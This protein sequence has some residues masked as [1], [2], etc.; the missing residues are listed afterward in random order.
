M[1]A[2]EL[3]QMGYPEGPLI[4]KARA[5]AGNARAA[6]RPPDQ[7]KGLMRAVLRRPHD[8]RADP[9]FGGLAQALI[10]VGAV[11]APAE[12]PAACFD[13][14]HPLEYAVWG[15]DIDP[16]AHEQMRNACRL[17]ISLAA[18]LMPDAHVGYGLPIGGVLAT[19]NAV[20][21]YAVGVDIA[22]RMMLTVFPLP[23]ES[24]QADASRFKKVLEANTRFGIGSEWKVPR[25]HPVMDED[26]RVSPVTAE[27]KNLAHRQLGTS[28][29]GNHFV[30]FGELVVS[31]PVKGLLPGRYLAV[32]SHSGS[33]GTGAKV[34]DYYSK[35]AMSRHQDMP[36]ELRHLAWL[37]LNSAGAEYWAA[38]E[39]MGKYASANHH[40]IHRQI[41]AAVGADPLLQIENHHN[42]AWREWHNGR[43]VIVHRKGATP[44]GRGMLGII[45][46]SM[47]TPG[48]VV[49]GLGSELSL[50]S[51]A[52][53]AGRRMSRKQAI[54]QFTW[55][56]AKP[57]L[58][59]RG[60]TLISAGIDEVPWVYKDIDEVMAAQCD[61]VRPLAKFMPRLVKM[62]PAGERP[63]D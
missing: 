7:V 29:S 45:P 48:Y 35:W 36:R 44:A 50:N 9:V 11:S 41:V 18:A 20:I 47:A 34:A 62:A 52:H 39:L 32:L 40:V 43:E 26:W 42:F 17:P 38:M 2:K 57:Y 3:L 21:P 6:G 59:E 23:P 31:E 56:Q 60:V 27:L 24:L 22:C 58:A 37:D 51:A 8:Y 33:R 10:D 53:G 14:P 25:D 61:L 1:K 5:A 54:Q 4:N 19:D 49:E 55:A 28:G 30:E 63:E 16:A 12:E 15:Q 13:R 46:G